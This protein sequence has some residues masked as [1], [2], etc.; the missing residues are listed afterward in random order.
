MDRDPLDFV[1]RESEINDKPS[2]LRPNT[3][4][5]TTGGNQLSGP[6]IKMPNDND[7]FMIISEEEDDQAVGPNNNPM[8]QMDFIDELETVYQD[9]NDEIAE[10][11]G[12]K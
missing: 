2:K 8:S 1:R 6:N 5:L 10:T 7:D 12:N 9:A 11:A 3:T 4:K